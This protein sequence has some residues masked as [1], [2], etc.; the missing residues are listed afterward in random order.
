MAHF[1]FVMRSGPAEGRSYLLEGDDI[2]IGRDSNNKISINDAEVSRKH[3]R[4]VKQ[5]DGYVL[6]DFGSTNGTFINDQRLSG[7][8]ALKIGDVVA[9]GENVVLIYEAEFDPDATRLSSKK[10]QAVKVMPPP[11]QEIPTPSK[12][13]NLNKETP[14]GPAPIPS[15]RTA[16]KMSRKTLLIIIGVVVLLC[17]C[18]GIIY[19]YFAPCSFW[20]R[21]PFIPWA[22]CPN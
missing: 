8:K 19:L 10:G 6:E 15:P 16:S 1:R 20:M 21:I 5:G 12:A 22:G 11:V 17:I 13:P 4:L 2:S 14:T 7:S 3:A 18:G 9:L